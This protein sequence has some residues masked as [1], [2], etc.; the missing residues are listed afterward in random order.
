MNT[1][2]AF[3]QLLGMTAD[4]DKSMPT[5]SWRHLAFKKVLHLRNERANRDSIFQARTKP[6]KNLNFN[7]KTEVRGA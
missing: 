7:F 2:L 6:L 5:W 4:L 1:N 3:L